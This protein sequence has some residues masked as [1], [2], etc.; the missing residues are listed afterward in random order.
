M[1]F[2]FPSSSLFHSHP[3]NTKSSEKDSAASGCVSPKPTRSSLLC[4]S[5]LLWLSNLLLYCH[6]QSSKAV[7][8]VCFGFLIQ[9]TANTQGWHQQSH[10]QDTQM[11]CVSCAPREPWPMPT[12]APAS[13]KVNFDQRLESS[14]WSSGIF[15]HS[16]LLSP[17][18]YLHI[19]SVSY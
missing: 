14:V 11:L 6:P 1:G 10:H 8:W 15:C 19:Y 2:S 18:G 4:N 17:E 7:L 16:S 12:T 9:Q 3:R 13:A 5:I